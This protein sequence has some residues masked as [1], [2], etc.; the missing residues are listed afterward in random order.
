MPCL[1]KAMAS[2]SQSGLLKYALASE[3]DGSRKNGELAMLR[4]AAWGLSA[5]RRGDDCCDSSK[6]LQGYVLDVDEV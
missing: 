4:L 3:G 6:V 5:L 1:S 2:S